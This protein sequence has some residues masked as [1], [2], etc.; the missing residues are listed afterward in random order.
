VAEFGSPAGGAAP[1]ISVALC[2]YNGTNYL[3]EQLRSVLE[4]TRPPAQLVVSDDASSDDT[5]AIVRELCANAAFPVQI[6]EATQNSGIVANFERAMAA[7]TGEYIALSDQD[8]RWHPDKLEQVATRIA[9]EP[10]SRAALFYH[11]PEL[12]DGSGAPLGKTFLQS[13]R[14]TPPQVELWRMLCVGNFVPGCTMVF[15][16]EALQSLL[17]MP[18]Q[19]ILHDWWIL[20]YFS[21]CGEVHRMDNAGMSYRLHDD[22]AQGVGTLQSGISAGARQGFLKLASSNLAVT[23]RQARAMR[24]R[25]RATGMEYPPDYDAICELLDRP[26]YR[27][28]GF[29]RR[30]GVHRGNRLKTLLTLLASTRVQQSQLDD[31]ELTYV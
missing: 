13:A 21:L 22:N 2:T 24:D 8:D 1:T 12:I 28:P 6:L 7:C 9:A 30:L 23:L 31:P 29:L 3:R 11:D 27:R 16:R 14:L 19:A 15:A 17:P 25:L 5:L 20:L 10:A 26:G 18:A 4:Q